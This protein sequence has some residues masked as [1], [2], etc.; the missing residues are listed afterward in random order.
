MRKVLL[1]I[2]VL[3]VGVS[4]IAANAFGGSSDSTLAGSVGPGFT[5]SLKQGGKNVKSLKKGTYTLSVNDKTSAHNF[6]LEGPGVERQVTT[7]PGTGKKTVK[8]KLRAGKYKFYC[9]PHE[10]SMFGFVTVK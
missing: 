8:V 4:V 1:S 2:A 3:A 10:S 9:A 5:I 6:V 7:V